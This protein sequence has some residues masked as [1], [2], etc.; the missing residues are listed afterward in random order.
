MPRTLSFLGLATL[1]ACLSMVSSVHAQSHYSVG[2]RLSAEQSKALGALKVVEINHRKYQVL[3]TGKNAASLP[4][5]M[6][7][8]ANGTV[9][10]TYHEI[11][12]VEQP[13]E[14]VRQKLAS[15]LSQAQDVKSYDHMQLTLLRFGTLD[16]AIQALAAIHTAMPQAEVAL[17]ITV[18]HPSLR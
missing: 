1:F 9:G 8:D 7:L 13:T 15:V 2:Q 17:P 4:F 12:V 5:T 18:S 16:E 6:L 10:Q 14:Q 3:D 11:Q